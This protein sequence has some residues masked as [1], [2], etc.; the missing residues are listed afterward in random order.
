MVP[1]IAAAI[2]RGAFQIAVPLLF[3]AGISDGFDGFLARKL[4]QQ[5]RLGSILDPIADKALLVTVYFALCWAGALPVWLVTLVIGR[6]VAILL[7]ASALMFMRRVRDF[8]PSAWGKISTFYQMWLAGIVV[9]RGAWPQWV[10]HEI[11]IF[12]LAG[13]VAATLVSGLDYL[14]IGWAR[15]RAV[16][17]ARQG[18]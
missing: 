8:P 13:T 17:A 16:S 18:K 9:L 11:L 5:T 2:A 6:D 15:L 3:V 1:V 14:R 7:F 10:P 12:M 4:N